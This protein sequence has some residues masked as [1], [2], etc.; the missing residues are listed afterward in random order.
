MEI[1]TVQQYKK[2][3]YDLDTHEKVEG[4]ALDELF[5]RVDD[6]GA[7]VD[8]EAVARAVRHDRVRDDRIIARIRV[9]RDHP[10]VRVR[11]RNSNI[12][13]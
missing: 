11:V 7:R 12:H 10:V 6:A 8:L 3:K 9:E 13:M 1:I 4:H 2:H 5:L